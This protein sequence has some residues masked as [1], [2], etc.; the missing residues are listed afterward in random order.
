MGNLPSNYNSILPI[1]RQIISL[2]YTDYRLFYQYDIY[3]LFVLPFFIPRNSKIIA[4]LVTPK[5]LVY[6]IMGRWYLI[7]CVI[8]FIQRYPQGTRG[9]FTINKNP[10][11]EL[12]HECM[13]SQHHSFM[14][15]NSELTPIKMLSKTNKV[16]IIPLFIFYSVAFTSYFTPVSRSLNTFITILKNSRME[17]NYERNNSR[18]FWR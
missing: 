15:G 10:L 16:I 4:A 3:S 9:L 7:S 12:L 13:G 5:L 2:F 1:L 8:L 17:T 18:N 14:L 11:T 6:L